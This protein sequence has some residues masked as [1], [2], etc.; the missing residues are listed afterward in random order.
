MWWI[1]YGTDIIRSENCIW[2]CPAVVPGASV[3]ISFS[4]GYYVCEQYVQLACTLTFEA[5]H[6]SSCD[7]GINHP[8]QYF[9][10]SQKILQK[11]IPFI[12]FQDPWS[13]FP[14]GDYGKIGQMLTMSSSSIYFDMDLTL[15]RIIPHCNVQR[16]MDFGL[17]MLFPPK[18]SP[19]FC[20]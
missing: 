1:K 16:V 7:A 8:N 4:M 19:F 13:N 2:S 17:A 12:I 3:F 11:V 5:V 6:G 14:H 18:V 20:P 9:I 10:D 15:C